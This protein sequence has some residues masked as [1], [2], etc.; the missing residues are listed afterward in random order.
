VYVHTYVYPQVTEEDI[1]KGWKLLFS[2]RFAH[3][4]NYLSNLA[5]KN[6]FK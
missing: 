2:G 5:E 1:S 4:R 6:S 3:T